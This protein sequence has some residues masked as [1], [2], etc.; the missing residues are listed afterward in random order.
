MN[1]LSIHYLDKRR[2]DRP[3]H[4]CDPYYVPGI[5]VMMLNFNISEFSVICQ[6]KLLLPSPL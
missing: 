5:W 2:E 4:M 3:L 1:H 6:I